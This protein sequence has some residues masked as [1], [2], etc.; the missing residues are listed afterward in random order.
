LIPLGRLLFTGEATYNTLEQIVQNGGIVKRTL[1]TSQFTWE[2]Y[3]KQYSSEQN[4]I[5]MAIQGKQVIIPT[6]D[7]PLQPQAGW[8]LLTLTAQQRST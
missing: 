6:T 2:D 5:L 1:L 4:M 7:Q 8:E 3:R